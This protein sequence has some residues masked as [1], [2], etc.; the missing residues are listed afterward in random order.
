MGRIDDPDAV[1]DS[2]G[3]VIGVEGVRVTDASISPV[4][5]RANT[6]LTTVMVAER[7]AALMRTGAAPYPASQGGS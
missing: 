4:I 5:P 7:I 1:V 6:H 2:E 3:R